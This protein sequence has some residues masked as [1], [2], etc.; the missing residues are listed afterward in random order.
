ME[1]LQNIKKSLFDEMIVWGEVVMD[2][3]ER[4]LLIHYDREI[5]QRICSKYGFSPMKALESF[6]RS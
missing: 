1:L 6:I 3:L 4:E 2:T 5:V